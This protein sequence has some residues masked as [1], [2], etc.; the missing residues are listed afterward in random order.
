MCVEEEGNGKAI[1][2]CVS[3]IIH[4]LMYQPAFPIYLTLQGAE[5]LDFL[6]SIFFVCL[7][8]Y[9]SIFFSS[10]PL[11]SLFNSLLRMDDGECAARNSVH[12]SLLHWQG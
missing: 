5:R 3:S 12:R 8:T 10:I 1:G 7:D 6:L 4:Q 2:E 9:I 11:F